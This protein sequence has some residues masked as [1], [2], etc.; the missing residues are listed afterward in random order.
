M[1][2]PTGSFESFA[3]DSTLMLGPKLGTGGWSCDEVNFSVRAYALIS[4]RPC[5]LEVIVLLKS[6]PTVV[7]D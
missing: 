1:Q 2:V 3:Y 4:A 6:F 7:S 5:F